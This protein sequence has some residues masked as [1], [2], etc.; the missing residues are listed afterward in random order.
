MPKKLPPLPG[1]ALA[2]IITLALLCAAMMLHITIAESAGPAQEIK[3][4][5]P[6]NALIAYLT[7]PADALPAPAQVPHRTSVK[8]RMQP[9]RDDWELQFYDDDDDEWVCF[10]AAYGSQMSHAY[11]ADSDPDWGRI[12]GFYQ[13]FEALFYLRG[14]VPQFAGAACAGNALNAP[15]AA[16]SDLA[17]ISGTLKLTYGTGVFNP[18]EPPPGYGAQSDGIDSIDTL[19]YQAPGGEWV[20]QMLVSV[21]AAVVVMVILRSMAG[22]MIGIMVMPVSAFGMALI[23]YGSYWYVAVMVLIFVFAV[24]GFAMLTRQR[25]Y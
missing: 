5:P 17:V 22:L 1:L 18:P 16:D 23:G 15:S 6:D 25:G 24:A 9:A 10:N 12:I 11:S 21:G 3:R 4:R 2:V 19:I 14:V 7:N 13:P 20:T 8:F